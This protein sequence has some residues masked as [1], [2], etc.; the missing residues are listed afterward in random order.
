MPRENHPQPVAC[1]PL[2]GQQVDDPDFMSPAELRAIRQG[3]GVLLAY[4]PGEGMPRDLFAWYCGV[5][6]RAMGNYL[7]GYRSI[8]GA[9]RV[10][11]IPA[12]VARRARKLREAVKAGNFQLPPK[13]DAVRLRRLARRNKFLAL[14]AARRAQD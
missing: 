6:D 7:A 11:R 10:V 13:R 9:E 8:G 14:A 2:C 5:S 4:P 12:R 1:C 3:L